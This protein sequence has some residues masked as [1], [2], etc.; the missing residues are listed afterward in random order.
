MEEA[1]ID[2]VCT[3]VMTLSRMEQIMWLL[4][5][6]TSLFHLHRLY[7]VELYE[8]VVMNDG[9][10]WICQA[11]VVFCFPASFGGAEECDESPQCRT[12]TVAEIRTRYCPN[13]RAER[14]AT[15]RRRQKWTLSPLL[16]IQVTASILAVSPTTISEVFPHCVH[17]NNVIVRWNSQ[18]VCLSRHWRVHLSQSLSN[19]KKSSVIYGILYIYTEFIIWQQH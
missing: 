14:F 3:F 12:A 15:Y 1:W 5:Y 4:A 18:C 19:W 11:A 8:C 6:L 16:N 10:V 17:S 9:K 13:Q 7:G 2:E